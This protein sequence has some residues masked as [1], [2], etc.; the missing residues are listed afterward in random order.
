MFEYKYDELMGL[1]F[2]V[3]KQ[4]GDLA[5]NTEI[6]ERLIEILKLTEEE[7]G[8]I[9]RNSVTK[10]DYRTAWTKNYLKNVGYIVNSKRA[11]WSL[12]DKGNKVDKVNKIIYLLMCNY[13]LH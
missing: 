9:H 3:I 7:V 1:C 2:N 12:Y 11:V 4:L 13:R 10:L 6:R 8:D 5:T